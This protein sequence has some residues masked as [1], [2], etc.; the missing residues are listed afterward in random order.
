MLNR[1]TLLNRTIGPAR[2][3]QLHNMSS[4][5][6]KSWHDGPNDAFHGKIT[7]EGPFLPEKDR[8]HL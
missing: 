3:S 4:S 2:T 7:S 8:Y 1:L 5:F 6:A